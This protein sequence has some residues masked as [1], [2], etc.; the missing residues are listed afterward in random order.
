MKKYFRNIAVGGL[1][2]L[3]GCNN[4]LDVVPDD[5]TE[6]NTT[7]K[8][9]K[10]VADAYPKASY[11]AMLNSRVDFVT[12]K[13]SGKQENNSNT[14]LKLLRLVIFATEKDNRYADIE[15]YFHR[16]ADIFNVWLW[17]KEKTRR[18][19]IFPELSTYI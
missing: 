15:V 11:A 7:E 6:I 18:I 10:L 1:V 13:G 12:D 16:F 5:R 8:L 14:D 4:F 19:P 2:L 3:T 17:W 9:A